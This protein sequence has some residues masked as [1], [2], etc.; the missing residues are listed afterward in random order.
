MQGYLIILECDVVFTI[1]VMLCLL[2]LVHDDDIA[3]VVSCSM[4]SVIK[5]VIHSHPLIFALH[6]FHHPSP[7]R[8]QN[9]RLP[10]IRPTPNLSSLFFPSPSDSHAHTGLQLIRICV[11][12]KQN[13]TTLQIHLSTYTLIFIAHLHKYTRTP[14]LPIITTFLPPSFVEPPPQHHSIIPTCK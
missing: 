11:H 1:F 9:P 12:S 5:N 4:G 10:S 13:S 14:I 7:N 3:Q 2:L 6:S 8:T